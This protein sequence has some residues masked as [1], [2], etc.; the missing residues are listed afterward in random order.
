MEILA[1]LVVILVAI[2]LLVLVFFGAILPWKPKI[3]VDGIAKDTVV[4][5]FCGA[6]FILICFIILMIFVAFGYPNN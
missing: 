6:V 5:L 4:L 2:L 3:F 1:P